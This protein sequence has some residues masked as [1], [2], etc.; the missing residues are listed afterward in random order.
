MDLK[1]T[2]KQKLALELLLFLITP[3]VFFIFT[4]IKN[5]S[6]L[7]ESESNSIIQEQIAA[8]ETDLINQG[9]N[10]IN[11]GQYQLSIETNLKIL[12]INPRNK[13]ALNNIG[14][15]YANLKNWDRGIIYCKKALDIDPSF[16]LA[17][18]N[19]NWMLQEKDNQP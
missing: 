8:Q 13:F 17:K 1:L 16:Q 12:K 11:N 15:A 3:L 14:F 10:Y 6:E 2:K 7:Q 19:L 9:L 5:K 4:V 18:N